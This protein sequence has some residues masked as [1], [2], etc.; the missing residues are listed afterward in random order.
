MM[1]KKYL[2]FIKENFGGFDTLGE[3][4]EYLAKDNEY[5][6]QVVSEFTQSINSDVRISSAVNTLDKS[7]QELILKMIQDESQGIKPDKEVSVNSYTST[8]INESVGGRNI[9]KCFLKIISALGQKNS[10]VDWKLTPDN[11]LGMF[12]TN[13]VNS[14]E[15]KSV[16]SRYLYFDNFMKSQSLKSNLVKLYY[17]IRDDLNLEYGLIINNDTFTL[18]SFLLTQG[19]Y[20]FIMTLDLKSATNLKKYLVSLDLSKLSILSKVKSVMK[21]FFPGQSESKLEPTITGDIISYGFQGLGK[22]DNGQ[23]D[24]GELDNIK[25]NL[26]SHLMQYKWSD[27]IQFNVIPSDHWV[28]L[29]I[30]IK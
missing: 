7:T 19:T 14:D 2:Q 27:K 12:I 16:M 23:V 20:N 5:A 25:N 30:K 22:W 18:G 6:Q 21:D 24:M 9:F 10:E 8:T 26:R 1:L 4:I 3:Y 29:N 28:F 13:S 15:L 11:F 17:G